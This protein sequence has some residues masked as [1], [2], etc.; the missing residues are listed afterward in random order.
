MA[1]LVNSVPDDWSYL[2]GRLD[3]PGNLIKSGIALKDTGFTLDGHYGFK[4]EMI[5]GSRSPDLKNHV[6]PDLFAIIVE[7][8]FPGYVYFCEA[9]QDT[10]ENSN[11]TLASAKKIAMGLL[12]LGYRGGLRSSKN[13]MDRSYDRAAYCSIMFEPF[14]N[15]S[16]REDE[17]GKQPARIRIEYHPEFLGG[18]ELVDPIVN[19]CHQLELEQYVPDKPS[20][21]CA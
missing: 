9:G 19:I 12:K 10:R 14:E 3:A 2:D 20:V 8:S 1:A 15:M 16:W 4:E 5:T 21:V 6:S 11:L 18:P 17:P 13:K 7:R